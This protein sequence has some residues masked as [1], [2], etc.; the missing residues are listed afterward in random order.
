M[1][2]SE[3][4]PAQRVINGGFIPNAFGRARQ[5]LADIAQANLL[6][7]MARQMA[8][9]SIGNYWS[10]GKG[11]GKPARSAK[12][13]GRRSFN[14]YP[15]SSARQDARTARTQRTLV[16]NGFPLMQTIPARERGPRVA[17]RAT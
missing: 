15:F 14:H 4:V 1:S 6:T 16:V 11:K 9:D 12:K 7:G 2:N 10:R 17:A 8:L 13:P 5:M 3:T